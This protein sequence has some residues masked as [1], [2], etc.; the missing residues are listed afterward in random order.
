MWIRI[1]NAG[2]GIWLMFA[3]TVL[4]F[5]ES[6][7]TLLYIV[8]PIIAAVAIISVADSVRNLRYVNVLSG[9]CLL[10]SPL[11]FSYELAY[12]I[13]NLVTGLITIALAMIKG[14]IDD[15]FGGGWSSLFKSDPQHYQDA[16]H[17]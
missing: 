11:F 12:V 15:E 16:N 8:G 5:T 10:I 4:S 3:P 6:S 17:S 9:L 7:S 1:L 13:N 2:I 14:N